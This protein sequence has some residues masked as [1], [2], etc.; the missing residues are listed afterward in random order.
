M[1][2]L[3]E[4]QGVW[5]PVPKPVPLRWVIRAALLNALAYTDGNQRQAAAALE[6][7]ERV[8]NYALAREGLLAGRQKRPRRQTGP[9]RVTAQAGRG[10]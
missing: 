9:V 10:R 7:T 1:P 4:V 6:I 8:C 5:L 2:S 3:Y